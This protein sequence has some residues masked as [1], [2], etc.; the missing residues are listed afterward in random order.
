[1][2]L[3]V[4]FILYNLLISVANVALFAVKEVSLINEQL[5][6]RLSNNG[7]HTN[8]NVALKLNTQ[9]GITADNPKGIWFAIGLNDWPYMV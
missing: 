6:A 7:T 9:K 8:F 5:T 1:M 2:A 4:V 3:I